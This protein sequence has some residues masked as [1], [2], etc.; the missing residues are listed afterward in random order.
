MRTPHSPACEPD[1][2]PGLELSRRFYTDAVRP[3]LE[4]A[5]PGVPHSASRIGSGSE[6]LGYDTPRS[7]DHAWGPRLQ[8]FLHRH[9]VPRHAARIRHILAEHLPKTFLGHPTD[10]RVEV[11]GTSSWFTDTLGFDPAQG[12]TPADWLAL[13]TQ[14]LAEVTSG[15]VF[16]DGLHTLTPLR[17]ALRW[18]PHDVWLYVL[19]CQWQRIA[20]E[21]A[22]VGRCGEVG[23]ELGS[24]VNAARLARDLMRLCLLMDRR[25]PPYGK[26][27]GSTFARTAAGPRLSP[28]LTAALAATDWHT[29]ERHLVHAYEIV[30]H[31]HNQ[32]RLTDRVDPATRAYRSGPFQVLRADRFTAALTARITDPS[33][34][35]VP[36]VGAVDQFIDSTDVL[37]R[38]ESSRALSHDVRKP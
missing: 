23:D 24:A 13:P 12:I 37:S 35:D 2:V 30:A 29:R 15:A 38:P 27:L 34:K 21:E 5:A 14:L 10:R 20:Q 11:T 17:R 22:F 8:V 3:L 28:V 6:V 16:H 36:P 25:Y 9:D 1:F 4:E 18:Y 31:Q 33:L 32:L 7:A 19:A 26:W